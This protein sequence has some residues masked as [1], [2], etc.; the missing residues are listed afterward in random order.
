MAMTHQARVGLG[1]AS[2]AFGAGILGWAI[3]RTRA[4][5]IAQTAVGNVGVQLSQTPQPDGSILLVA[6]VEFTN[7]LQVAVTFGVQGAVL[8]ELSGDGGVIAGH[9]FTSEAVAEQADAYY[10]AGNQSAVAA[11]VHDPEDRVQVLQ[12]QPGATGSVTFYA[13]LHPT[14]IAPGPTGLIVWIVPNPP[15]GKLLASDPTGASTATIT[16]PGGHI[17]EVQ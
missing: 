17:V 8:E 14:E 7:L 9:L 16:A 1:V 2:A 11:I 5:Q 15:H 10:Y 12:V 6:T 13:F 3:Y 4:Q